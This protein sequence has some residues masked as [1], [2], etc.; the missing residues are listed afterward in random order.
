MSTIFVMSV[1]YVNNINYEIESYVKS[2][3][4]QHHILDS[5]KCTEYKEYSKVELIH[6][7]EKT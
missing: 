6:R 3:K 4:Q 5:N 7:I 1:M 2:D